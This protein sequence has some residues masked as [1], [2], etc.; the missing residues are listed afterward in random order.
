MPYTWATVVA[1]FALALAVKALR[2]NEI[3]PAFWSCSVLLFL[4]GTLLEPISVMQIL[5]AS[6]AVLYFSYLGEAVKARRAVFFFFAA[7]LA[8][9]VMLVAPGTAIRMGKIATIAFL[10]RFFRTLGIAVVFG[11]FTVVKFFMNPIMYVFL[12]FLPSITRNVPSF[13]EGVARRLRAWHIG[14]ITLLRSEE[15]RVGKECRSRWS[16]YH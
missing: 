12:L 15:R 10:P 9:L 1:L 5:L 14:L 16:P 8:F 13:D 11:F 2:Q 4:N 3:G 6:L 7:L